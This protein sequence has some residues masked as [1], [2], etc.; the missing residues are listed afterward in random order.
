MSRVGDNILPGDAALGLLLDRYQEIMALPAN[1][2]NGLNKPIEIP[3]YECSTIWKQS[4]RDYL[5]TYIAMAEEMREQ[6]LGY[7]VA[8]KYTADEEQNYGVPLTLNKKH[9]IECGARATSVIEAGAALDLGPVAPS[10]ADPPNDPVEISITTVVAVSEIAVFYPGEDVEIRPSSVS[11]TGGIVTIKI[12]RARLVNPVY[13]DN[14][15]DHLD[16]YDNDF[17]LTTVDVKRVYTDTGSGIVIVWDSRGR[18]VAGVQ[19]YPD[20]RETEQEAVCQIIGRQA[21][22]ISEVH[23]YPAS[24]GIGAGFTYCTFPAILRLSYLSGRQSSPRTEI[25]T[26]RLAHV[27]MPNVPCTCP[28][29]KEYWDKDR[30]DDP[31][32]LV[33]P[34]GYARGAVKA[35]LSDSRAKVGQGGKFPPARRGY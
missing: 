5:A 23:V 28:Y 16:Y 1:A 21:Y 17:F 30:V 26:A 25:E 4:D 18:V 8:P 11:A 20:G 33:T 7:Y 34:Y 19:T 24:G 3:R 14:R 12:P 35:W 22:R 31:S 13:N 29:V 2:F 15:E 9:L 6:E 32:G 27:E 10:E